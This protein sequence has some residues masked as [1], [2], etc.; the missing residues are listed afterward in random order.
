M[1]YLIVLSEPNPILHQKALPVE[2]IDDPL[3]SFIDDMFS[4]MEKEDGIGLAANQVGVLKRIFVIDV[5]HDE[6]EEDD[7]E[8]IHSTRLALIN[9]EI[10]WHSDS[11]IA[12]REG[13][14]SVPEIY[15]K[16]SRF[17]KVRVRYLDTFGK[18][19]EIEAEGLLSFCLQHELDHINGVLFVD[20]L[21][22][23][24]RALLRKKLSKLKDSKL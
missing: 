13:C 20:R 17:E 11:K 9:P 19:Q 10:I 18:H 23:L 24:K 4:T 14:L 3:R 6:E 22:S 12:S 16:V 15:E 2:T 5:P 1:T 21:S 7:Q 8:K